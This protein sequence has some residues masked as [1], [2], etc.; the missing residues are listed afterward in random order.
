MLN[1][2]VVC[3]QIRTNTQ[4]Q[5]GAVGVRKAASVEC[6]IADCRT[7]SSRAHQKTSLK[8]GRAKIVRTRNDSCAL[9]PDQIQLFGNCCATPPAFANED[10]VAIICCID[11]RL[12]RRKVFWYMNC[13]P[14]IRTFRRLAPVI[15]D[16]ETHGRGFWRHCRTCAVT[17]RRVPVTTVWKQPDRGF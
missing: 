14:D 11:G 12:N 4:G 17:T 9:S 6:K 2:Y 7:R 16:N 1:K 10:R 8:I 13:G 3:L 5:G 15:T